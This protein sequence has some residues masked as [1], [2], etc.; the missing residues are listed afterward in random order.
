MKIV[1]PSQNPFPTFALCP[2][3]YVDNAVKNN[4][5]MKELKGKDAKIDKEK[6]MAQWYNLYNVLAANS[7]VYLICPTKGLQDQTYVN[8]AAYLPH[9]KDRD[10]IILSN[11]TADGRTGEEIVAGELFKDLGYELY[12]CPFRFEGE[13]E[14][15][16]L[17]DDVYIGGYGFRSDIRAH[18]WIMKH[19]GGTIIPLKETDEGLYHLDCS[20]FPLN[21][22][23]TMIAT[24]LVDKATLDM[25]AKYTNIV[26]VTKDDADRGIAN[27]LMVEG[28]LYNS[29]SLKYMK[30]SDPDYAKELKK[31]QH[32]EKIC[33][34]LGL[35]VLYFNLDECEKSGAQCSCFIMHLNYR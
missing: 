18:Q 5:W 20:V 27:S 2:P 9:V 10:V 24:D 16:Y 19:F 14:L 32:L 17:H 33:D 29:S 28:V 12:Q 31:N 23:N 25:I 4:K 34:K 6:F 11:F 1:T 8:C 30:K 13:P 3:T 7:L 22:E 21:A 26:S 35:E 15:K